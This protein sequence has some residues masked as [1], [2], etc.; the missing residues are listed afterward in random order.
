METATNMELNSQIYL[1]SV[2]RSNGMSH[3]TKLSTPTVY[4]S[5]SCSLNAPLRQREK[6][7]DKANILLALAPIVF[8]PTI[9]GFTKEVLKLSLTNSD[10]P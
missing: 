6:L 2:G 10:L 5:F 1:Y 7:S 9:F 8:R 4:F 3:K